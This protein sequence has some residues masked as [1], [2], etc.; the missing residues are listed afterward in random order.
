MSVD[1]DADFCWEDDDNSAHLSNQ[2]YWVFVIC[3]Q[4]HNCKLYHK[5]MTVFFWNADGVFGHISKFD[6]RKG[7]I[8][9][10]VKSI[11]QEN[12][13]PEESHKKSTKQLTSI[14]KNFMNQRNANEGAMR[15]MEA[16]FQDT[17]HQSLM[18]LFI[19]SLQHLML[20][21]L[22]IYLNKHMLVQE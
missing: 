3:D 5:N 12:S 9:S 21:M 6:T 14:V 11:C 7:N 18:L 20:L 19:I 13:K 2:N 8:K 17:L 22:K 10:K 16:F 1:S 4:C 15:H